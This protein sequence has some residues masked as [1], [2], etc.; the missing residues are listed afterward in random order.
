MNPR[1]PPAAQSSIVPSKNALRAL[2]RL[3]LSSPVLVAS[4]LGGVC[5]IVTLNYEVNRRVRLAEQALE[6]KKIIRALSHGRGA[7]QLNAM[8]GAAERGEDFTL[9]TRSTK[10]KRKTSTRDF[11]AVALQ[12]QSEHTHDMTTENLRADAELEN[13]PFIPLRPTHPHRAH[14]MA[15]DKISKATEF[16]HRL[17]NFRTTTH[18]RQQHKSEFDRGKDELH[19]LFSE[20]SDGSAERHSDFTKPKE[21]WRK[22]TPQKGQKRGS[23][24]LVRRTAVI[25]PRQAQ[26]TPVRGESDPLPSTTYFPIPQNNLYTKDRHSPPSLSENEGNAKSL[27]IDRFLDQKNS[28]PSPEHENQ[29][30][31][32]PMRGAFFVHGDRVASLVAYLDDEAVDEALRDFLNQI[33]QLSWDPVAV[34]SLLPSA[35]QDFVNHAINV[36]DP[37]TLFSLYR[38]IW[39]RNKTPKSR[40]EK[41]YR[42]WLAVMRHYTS[43]P[44][45]LNWTIAEAVFHLYF[46]HQ[47]PFD[48]KGLNVRPVFD[49]VQHLLAT[50]STPSRVQNILFPP[51]LQ[52][53]VDPAE[54]FQL[55]VKYLNF[56]CE[57]QHTIPECLEETRKIVS[58]AR[59]CSLTP[60]QDIIVPVL[61][62]LVRS[63]D[64]EDA[65][66]ILD[67]LGAMFENID[68]LALLSE[69]AFQHACEGNWAV[70]ESTLDKIHMVNRS[71]D[72]PVSF[73]RLFQRLLMQ[74][75]AQNPSVQSFGFTVHAIKYAGLI[76]TGVI[77]RTLICACIRDRRHDLVAEWTRLVREAFPR[78]SFGF[79]LLQGGWILA[80]T[81]MEV[82]ASC[83]EVAKVCLAIA[84]G[85]RKNP[86]GP[87]FR[88]FAVGLIKT[89]MVQR[90]CATS[91]QLSAPRGDISEMSLE[92]LLMLAIDI[93]KSS[94]TSRANDVHV[95]GLKSDIAIQMSAII[96]LAKIFRGD[97]KLLFSGNKGQ[98]E[99]VSKRRRDGD[100]SRW[101]RGM[102][103]LKRT[104]PEL[105]EQDR[106]SGARRLTAAVVEYYDRRE[107]RGLPVDHAVLR[108]VI[109]HVGPQH[110]AE[111]LELVE[112]IYA[113][114]YVQRP[115]GTPFDTDLF[116]QWLL[117]VST[118]GTVTSA[119]AALRAV[120]ESRDHVE[121]TAHFRNLC[122]WVTQVE[123][124]PNGSYWA[125]KQYP[126]KPQGGELRP[127]FERIWEIWMEVYKQ[128]KETSPE[129]FK[130]PEWSGWET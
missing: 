5:G 107:K 36:L 3:A 51:L 56:F 33:P 9:S 122:E 79:D 127:L 68:S 17:P 58:I 108:Q 45:A 15:V 37:K 80:D 86:F 10:R 90:L 93:R 81:L 6:S 41:R 82:G 69:Y 102:G 92:K 130:F 70:V 48:S 12:E 71:R 49:L 39:R 40:R 22:I 28:T 76:P 62:A 84:H 112:A 116:K 65:E 83:E 13:V 55:S 52:D 54:V 111:T 98:T 59:R 57:D 1:V 63:K 113:S 4:T 125:E 105:F 61:K 95:E 35:P 72:R 66:I 34:E 89:D 126:K 75:T 27:S 123:S 96:D 118:N 101:F 100:S 20:N 129:T 117:L 18:P 119:A 110:P 74:H 19:N 38:F 23:D 109:T 14:G 88:E 85:C 120:V 47:R 104:F 24:L 64:F 128:R 50:E 87:S 32:G 94:T 16:P 43:Q 2:R 91:A 73:A 97:M 114:G 60:S 46:E 42:C 30:A 44:S 8:I 7:N 103:V 53:S 25:D 26:E 29:G 67:Q 77:S 115:E 21:L 78:V 124:Y 31:D 121:W 106:S 11:S 99:I